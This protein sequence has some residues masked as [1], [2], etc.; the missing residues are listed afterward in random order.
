MFVSVSP[1]EFLLSLEGLIRKKKK[2]KKNVFDPS[3][4]VHG[5]FRLIKQSNE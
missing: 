5:G 3:L 1:F 2:K 4:Y